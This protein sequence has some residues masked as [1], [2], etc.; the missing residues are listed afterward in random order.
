MQFY[1]LLL[2]LEFNRMAVGRINVAWLFGMFFCGAGI[3]MLLGERSAVKGAGSFER[4]GRRDSVG[5]GSGAII[6]IV[7]K[8]TPF[9]ISKL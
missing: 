1:L 9:S 7:W 6:P 5:T 8:T 4:G 2:F 3:G